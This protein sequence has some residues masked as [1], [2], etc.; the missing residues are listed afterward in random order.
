VH[1]QGLAGTL[2]HIA[3]PDQPAWK[4]WQQAASSSEAKAK[5]VIWGN[6]PDAVKAQFG[7]VNNM[8]SRDFINAWNT[9]YYQKMVE[10]GL[11]PGGLSDLP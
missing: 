9:F 2:S 4:S 10:S 8:T 1:Q 7:S 6:L 3:N 11:S 5:E